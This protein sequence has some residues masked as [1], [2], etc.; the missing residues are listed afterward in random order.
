MSLIALPQQWHR[1]FVTLT[2]FVVTGITQQA[3]NADD[4]L[5]ITIFQTGTIREGDFVP[6][7]IMK[8]SES[9]NHSLDAVSRIGQE[10]AHVEG[11][12]IC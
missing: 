7:L 9:S 6:R 2:E 8:Q 12:D 11:K 3:S 10:H 1:V 4:A 5:S